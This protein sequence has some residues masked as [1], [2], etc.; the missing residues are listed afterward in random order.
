MR[1][2]LFLLFLVI[3]IL[4]V[5]VKLMQQPGLYEQILQTADQH[6]LRRAKWILRSSVGATPPPGG[7]GG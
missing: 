6:Q 2:L 5:S 3:E 7:P 1:W 4:P